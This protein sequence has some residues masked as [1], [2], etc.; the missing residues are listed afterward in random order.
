MVVFAPSSVGSVMRTCVLVVL[1]AGLVGCKFDSSSEH[2]DDTKLRPTHLDGGNG[3]GAQ[4]G[5][6]SD[7]PG[8][9]VGGNAGDQDGAT[10][11]PL[12]RMDA[13]TPPAMDGGA[14]DAAVDGGQFGDNP[15]PDDPDAT[16][17]NGG[18]KCADTF[19]PF[20]DA[21]IEPCCTSEADVTGGAARDVDRCGLSFAKLSSDFYGTQCWQRDQPGV[22]DD[23]CSAVQVDLH[24]EDPGCCS[25]QG[26]CGGV[27]SDHGLGCHYDPSATQRS[28]GTTIPD[29][30]GT[31]SECDVTGQYALEYDV[32]LTWGGRSGG[33]WEL[34][35]DGRGTQ[36]IGLLVTIEHVDDGTL[37]ITGTMRTCAV[38]LPAFYSTTLCEAYQPVFPN[39]LWE[40][41]EM[42]AFEFSGGLQCAQPGCI[43]TI[44]A[45]TVLLGISLTNP[46]APWPTADQTASLTC[47]AGKGAQ[48]FP[49]QDGDGRPGLG[50]ELAKT[51]SLPSTS[52]SCTGGYVKKG[53]PLSSS[54]AAIFDGVRRTDRMQLGVRMKVGGS[55]TLGDAC[56]NGEG[57]GIAQFVNSRG[58]SCL[59]Q[60]GTAN[61]PWGRPA[62]ASDACTS[63]EAQFLDA[64]LPL[65]QILAVGEKPSSTLTLSDK[66]ASKGPQVRLVRL[67][68]LD[69]GA[70]CADVRA[71][72][73]K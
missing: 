15:T 6:G 48:C 22:V 7:A 26:Y 66:S 50:V 31:G 45:Q 42:P 47:P 2:V 5:A 58:W 12:S 69:A 20:A 8:G 55:I 53:A 25:D 27:D 30:A 67:G 36:R 14:P 61:Y 60:Q 17:Q 23:T 70:T 9:N 33:L 1:L 29:D 59:V 38:E 62:G 57:S 52:S 65:Y 56:A 39:K 73:S 71:A 21:P 37:A 49:D 3:S 46:E 10:G 32:D 68:A 40:A 19:C 43:A 11:S 24:T 28:C 35:D 63:A 72:I 54:V 18:L 13:T 4:S 44:D 34:T 16:P 41:A 51:G 64:N